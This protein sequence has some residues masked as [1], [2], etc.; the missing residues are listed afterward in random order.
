[1]ANRHPV[2]PLVI[3][4]D[5]VVRFRGNAIV[6]YLLELAKRNG[7]G[8]NELAMMGFA[9]ADFEQLAQL[10]GYS[11]SGFGEL[12]YVSDETYALAEAQEPA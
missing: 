3:D 6:R 9:D 1:M 5:G 7:T 12:S 2:Q 8:L 11:L 10:L 4:R